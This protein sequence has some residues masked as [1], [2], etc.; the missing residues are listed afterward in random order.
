MN[1]KLD[2]LFNRKP[3]VY[4]LTF[5]IILDI[6]LIL[7]IQLQSYV[8]FSYY[9]NNA[10][11]AIND[12]SMSNLTLT[13]KNLGYYNTLA[14]ELTIQ[15]FLSQEVRSYFNDYNRTLDDEN[16]SFSLYERL[17]SF[18]NT[19]QFIHSIYVY[20]SEAD[21]IV[22]SDSYNSSKMDTFFDRDIVERIRTA[23]IVRG[24]LIARNVKLNDG[25]I[26]K[27]YSYITADFFASKRKVDTAVVVNLKSDWMKDI[28]EAQDKEAGTETI[29]ID[30]MGKIMGSKNEDEFFKYIGNRNYIK[31][32]LSENYYDGYFYQQINSIDYVVSFSK[33]IKTNW[34]MVKLTPYSIII[35]K[36]EV[37][38]NVGNVVSLILILLGIIIG[39]LIIRVIYNPLARLTANVAS[40]E[41]Y[42]GESQYTIKQR[43]LWSLLFGSTQQEMKL[44]NEKMVNLDIN[45][46][47]GSP[48]VL[49]VIRVDKYYD[50]KE[51][52]PGKD[53]SLMLFAI[54][55][56][57]GELLSSVF[58]N[59]PVVTS[60]ECVTVICQY[61]STETNHDK[62][63]IEAICREIQVNVLKYLETSVT[64]AISSEI[65]NISELGYAYND[66]FRLTNKRFFAGRASVIQKESFMDN[67]SGRISYEYPTSAIKNFL[68]AMNTGKFDNSREIFNTI[69]NKISD[70]TYEEIIFILKYLF[71][72]LSNLLKVRFSVA[73]INDSRFL[74]SVTKKLDRIEVLRDAEAILEEYI[75]LI[76]S[77]SDEIKVSKFESTVNEVKDYIDKNHMD[78][79]LSLNYIANVFNASPVYFGR[80]FKM[81]VGISIQEYIGNIR[82]Q[83]AIV[84]LKDESIPI[85][86]ICEKVGFIN[87]SHFFAFFKK[88]MGVTPG[89]FRKQIMHKGG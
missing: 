62:E 35:S 27:Y 36:L 13:G 61:I 53:S 25:D 56:I 30:Q 7:V 6:V 75:D 26:I 15:V 82:L 10:V 68:E 8:L 3:K 41:R 48:F 24:T 34:W 86:E 58:R 12:M 11:T 5:L 2:S 76:K 33:E 84:M 87:K 52:Y 67:S 39:A 16:Q 83:S 89:E 70:A 17:N 88:N 18:I 78:V 29:F 43:I 19:S 51:R 22:S 4:I 71:L 60:D 80:M 69:V 81:H 31:K 28:L 66:T 74:D 64:I 46:E 65:Q 72:N 21:Y 85:N 79:N 32:I 50:F 20:N 23:D 38:R 63:A 57:A 49:F 47:G 77:A 55:N 37:Y 44:I 73:K 40:L 14:R 1:L 42:K 9:K 59:E 45:P 54:G